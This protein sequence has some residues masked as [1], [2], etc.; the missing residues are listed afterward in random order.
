MKCPV[1]HKKLTH[2]TVNMKYSSDI[3]L[4]VCRVCQGV[5][6]DAEELKVLV[7]DFSSDYQKTY[8]EWVPGSGE[9]GTTVPKDF[10]QESERTCPKDSSILKR[11]YMGATHNVGIDQC[12]VCQGFWFDGSEL[13]A[14]AKANEPNLRLDNAISGAMSGMQTELGDNY[15]D[16]NVLWWDLLNRP[17]TA[18]P[19]IKDMLLNLMIAVITRK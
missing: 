12:T 17:R 9:G 5:W 8:K 1:D 16:D 18:L 2:L 6:V 14:V 15:K 10:W 13:Y 19:Y 4:D 11:H 3:N 7:S